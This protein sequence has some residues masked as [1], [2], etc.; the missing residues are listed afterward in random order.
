MNYDNYVVSFMPGSRGRLFANLIYKLA[1]NDPIP[2][3]FTEHNSAHNHIDTWDMKY[4]PNLN[5][6]YTDPHKTSVFFTHAYPNLKYIPP[7]TGTV[8]INVSSSKIDE[9]CLNAV[10]KNVIPKIEFLRDGGTLDETQNAFMKPYERFLPDNYVDILTDADKLRDFLHSIQSSFIPKNKNYYRNF[11]DN[12]SIKDTEIFFIDY[13]KMFGQEN[14]KYIVLKRLT[15]WM[16]V[17]YTS[18]IHNLYEQYDLEKFKIFDKY[19]P[20]F[21]YSME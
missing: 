18:E 6:I 20:W 3:S 21:N 12:T 10:I 2:I 15:D 16:Q 13:E 11:I 1:N 7:N 9:V 19:C 14:E 4:A 8:F 5:K 17:D